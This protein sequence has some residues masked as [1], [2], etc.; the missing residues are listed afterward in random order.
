M[1]NNDSTDNVYVNDATTDSAKIWDGDEYSETTWL[2]ELV[3]DIEADSQLRDLVHSNIVM[4]RNG[5]IATDSKSAALAIEDGTA[6]KIR[7]HNNN[8]ITLQTRQKR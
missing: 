2:N 6:T 7:A 4:L 1:P 5:K 3:D 8:A